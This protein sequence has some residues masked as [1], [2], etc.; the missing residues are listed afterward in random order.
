VI[1]G[2]NQM[3][4]TAFAAL[5]ALGVAVSGCA[6][7]VKGSSESLVVTTP[8]VTGATCVLNNSR[9]SYTVTTPGPVTVQ[10]SKHDIQIRCNKDGYR[11][12]TATIPS[13]FEGWTLGNIIIGGVG[14]FA[15]DAATGAMN[16]YPHAFQVP[17]EPANGYAP[18]PA[19]SASTRPTT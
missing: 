18:A 4:L 13:D 12:A 6:S 10:R 17:M 5:A 15:V 3:K 9:G 2:A 7:V 1:E 11:E 8:P 14:G 19:T 16:E